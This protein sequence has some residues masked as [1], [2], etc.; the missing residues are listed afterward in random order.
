MFIHTYVLV[1]CNYH[2][3]QIQVDANLFGHGHNHIDCY[4]YF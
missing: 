1:Q 4:Y 2:C 3:Y